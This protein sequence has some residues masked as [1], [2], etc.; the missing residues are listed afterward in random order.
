MMPSYLPWHAQLVFISGLAEVALGALL[1]FRR[2][3]VWAGWGLIALLVA[4]FPANVQMAMH[5]D[6]YPGI[7]PL[8]LW[9]RLPL[10]PI[11][12]AWVWWYTRR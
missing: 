12:I 5:P 2:W 3:A 10:Q 1:I 11:L 8:M 9:L 4:V 6:L 7:S